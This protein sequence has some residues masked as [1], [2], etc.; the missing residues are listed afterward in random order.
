M[1]HKRRI[2]III[3]VAVLIPIAALAIMSASSSRPEDLGIADGRLSP[4]PETPNCISTQAA[5]D[6]HRMEPVPFVGSAQA[7]IGQLKAVIQSMPRTR[8]ITEAP[9]Y[10]HVE[11]TS[12]L[13]RFI[14]DLEFYLDGTAKLI[15]FRSAS[16]SGRSDLGANR[17]RINEIV[18]GLK[19]SL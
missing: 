15:H 2:V 10:L 16:R 13:F 19:S 1:K 17:R 18:D 7:K 4:C 6:E 5:D 9:N 12:L 8:I 3:V 11:C 14:D